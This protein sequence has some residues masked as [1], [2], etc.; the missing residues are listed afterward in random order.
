MTTISIIHVY[1]QG[2]ACSFHSGYNYKEWH[3]Q[4]HS[5]CIHIRHGN[6]T[7][8]T[9]HT[10]C[11]TM[12]AE[13]Y[14]PCNL[15]FKRAVS[16]M[17][18]CPNFVTKLTQNQRPIKHLNLHMFAANLTTN[19]QLMTDTTPHIKRSK[20]NSPKTTTGCASSKV[21]EDDVWG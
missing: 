11:C 12:F 6:G 21:S 2:M 13:A 15:P 16:P 8:C 7:P 19:W 9:P 1:K 5:I 18:T 4:F 20:T 14:E 10:S 17:T 3:D